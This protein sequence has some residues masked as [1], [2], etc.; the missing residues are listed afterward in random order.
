MSSV[1][2]INK[3]GGTHSP[4]ICQLSLQIWKFIISQNIQCHASHTSGSDNYIA[5]SLSRSGPI[6][7]DYCLDK[8][9]FTSLLSHINFSL[10]IDLFA[11]RLKYKIDP[12][13]SW[14][15]DRYDT[16]FNAFSFKWPNYICF[17]HSPLLTK[18]VK[19]L[20]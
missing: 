12:Y 3:M 20:K 15:A 18:P 1:Y 17:L 19:N 4:L 5:D 11:S 13:V 2:Y 9:A 10:S 6:P 8:H 7:R 16:H 14:E